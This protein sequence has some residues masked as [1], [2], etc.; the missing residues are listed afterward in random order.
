LKLFNRLKR[1]F[2]KLNAN[3][4]VVGIHHGFVIGGARK[5]AHLLSSWI[6]DFKNKK[7]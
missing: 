5:M 1:D 6:V 4:D 7:Q 2:P 3:L